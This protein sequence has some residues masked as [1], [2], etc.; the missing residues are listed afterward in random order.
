MNK[1]GKLIDGKVVGGIEWLKRVLPD[2]TERQGYT[3]NASRGC[4][5]GCAW[6]MPDG[7]IAQCY[8]K[9]VAEGIAQGAYPQGFETPTWHEDA[10]EEPL[11]VKE[12]A[13]IFV[14]SMADMMGIW[15]TDAQIEQMLDV[16]RRAD[17]HDFLL[18]TKNAPRL[19]KF[20]FP[21]NVWIGAS[22]PPTFMHGKEMSLDQQ[23]QMLRS[24][25]NV[26]AEI[27]APVKWISFEPLSFDV[28]SCLAWANEQ[29]GAILNWAVI[30]AASNGSTIYQP[31]PLIV[32]LAIEQLREMDCQIFFKGNMR[33]NDAAVPWL[34]EFPVIGKKPEATTYEQHHLI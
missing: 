4:K 28:S 5:H 12:P 1:Q 25:L 7:Q 33:G 2:G 31:K 30:G 21:R 8:A 10:L 18:L 34:E 11:R 14:D 24:T 22:V 23:R 9:T 32:R 16:C 13:R 3:W 6:R 29:Y 15:N 20:K 27:S 17:W 26:L 19:R